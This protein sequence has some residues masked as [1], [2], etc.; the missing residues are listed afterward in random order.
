MAHGCQQ[1]CIAD[2]PYFKDDTVE[3]KV[4]GLPIQQVS[5]F[6]Y[7]GDMMRHECYWNN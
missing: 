2:R 6:P 3:I 7:L 5:N 4:K 1:N